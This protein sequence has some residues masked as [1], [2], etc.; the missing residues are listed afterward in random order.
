MG[1]GD[2][3]LKT[4]EFQ[5]FLSLGQKVLWCPGMRMSLAMAPNA[6]LLTLL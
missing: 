4:A 1:T 6:T 3:L 5:A 2:W